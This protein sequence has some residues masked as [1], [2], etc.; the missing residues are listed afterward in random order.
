VPVLA[1]FVVVGGGSAR[2]ADIVNVNIASRSGSAQSNIPVTFGQ[3][4]RAG[5]VPS[6]QTVVAHLASGTAVPLQVDKKATYADGSLR[7]A[8]LTLSLPS[9][10]GNGV[11]PITLASGSAAASGTN[12]QLSDLLATGFDT[13]VTLTVGGVNYVASARNALSGSPQQ[14]LQGPFVSEWIAGG[15]ISTSGGTANPHLAVYFHVRAYG[16]PVTAARVDVVVEND[17]TLVAS[18]QDV[19]YDVSIQVPG[20][21]GYSQSGLAHY[22][23]ARWHQRLW[24]GTA[25]SVYAQLDTNYLQS[26][27]L[28]PRYQSVQPDNAY[29]SSLRR[30]TAPMTNGDITQNMD[31]TGAQDD[32]APLPRWDAVYAVSGDV[33]AYDAALANAD[34]AAVYGIHYRDEKTGLPVTIDSYPNSSIADPAGSTPMLPDNSTAN[35]YSPGSWS[36][37]QP[38]IG[39]L[40]YLLTGDYFYLEEMQFWSAYNLIWVS[41]P[42][43]SNTQGYW[44]TGSLRGQAWA[45]R[46][47]AQTAVATPDNHALKSYFSTKLTNNISNDTQMYVSPGGTYKNNLGAM[48]MAEGNDQYRFYD[49]FMSWAVQY[50]VDLGFTQAA[51]LRDYKLQFPIGLMGMAANEYCFQLAPQYTWH[52]GPVGTN[53]FYTSF[54]QVYQNTAP[55]YASLAC[56]SQQLANALGL[57]LNGMVGSQ[58]AVDSYYANLQ[59][60]LAAA[61]DSGLPGGQTAWNRTLLAGQQPDYSDAPQWALLPHTLATPQIIVQLSATPTTV[62]AGGTATLSWSAANADSCSAKGGWTTSQSVSG[63]ATVGPLQSTTVYE[64][65]C[66]SATL[67]TKAA[68]ATVTVTAGGGGGGGSPPPAPT[69]TLSA[70]PTTVASGATTALTWSSTN[71]TS[72]TASG[73]WS[74]ALAT[75][76]SRASAA[77]T[78]ATTFT[79]SCTGSGGSTQQS[80]SVAVQGTSGSA[81]PPPTTSP[82]AMPPPATSPP[83]ATPAAVTTATKSGGGA[84][85]L[86]TLL[87]LLAA[88]AMAARARTRAC[89]RPQV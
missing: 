57:P 60:A 74:G 82:P 79:L 18:P 3:A 11:Q 20:Q 32:I 58:T 16:R 22:E 65:D 59:A 24:W 72:C 39:F 54:Q 80:V 56:G 23:H 49:Y 66:T 68:T 85:E 38:A 5:D 50:L 73:G 19:T 53:V 43:R 4:F 81:P 8:I 6:G 31:D 84:L 44:Y 28:I 40:A 21:T 34:G 48:Y 89:S 9:L 46:N 14:W 45:Y 35:P 1:L 7:H 87:A 33:R 51:P 69:V 75:S 30:S 63:T 17:W 25:P 47:L 26:T 13:T 76:G 37:H 64:L 78:V 12:V 41:A 42:D 62:A 10:A 36:S 55:S 70:N 86:E 71:A 77:L 52:V 88:V 29:L 15:P 2:A 67:G 27:K 83:A 61:Y